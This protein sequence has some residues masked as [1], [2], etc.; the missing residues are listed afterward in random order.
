MHLSTLAHAARRS[1]HAQHVAE[2]LEPEAVKNCLESVETV[3]YDQPITIVGAITVTALSSG[4]AIGASNW[5]LKSASHTVGY[6]G[7]SSSAISR[8]P[9]P[10]ATTA[11]QNCDALIAC[12][13]ARRLGASPDRMVAE[14]CNNIG[15]AIAN[16]GCALVPC[17]PFGVVFDL[18]DAVLAHLAAMQSSTVPIFF[19]SPTAKNSLAYAN[20][21]GHWLCASK[22]ER[23]NSAEWPFNHHNQIAAK[24]LQHFPAIDAAF[25]AAYREPCVVFADHPSLR[26]GDALHFL[27][28]WRANSANALILT[29]PDYGIDEVLAPFLPVAMRASYCPIDPRLGA[30]AFEAVV[31]ETRPRQLLLPSMYAASASYSVKYEDGTILRLETGVPARLAVREPP[32]R[33]ILTDEV[34]RGL[35][36]QSLPSGA[37]IGAFR[38]TINRKDDA[39]IVTRLPA[40]PQ[41]HAALHGTLDSD[42]LV[43]ALQEKGLDAHV[44]DC[45]DGFVVRL[46]ASNASIS[47]LS[48]GTTISTVSNETLRGVL[49]DAVLSQLARF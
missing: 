47:V 29:D 17:A 6:L 5:V 39:N 20:I 13:L 49:R 30:Q 36:L 2:L 35:L 14:L 46:P 37:S 19:V 24:S 1:P 3:S 44:E 43:T 41:T 33:A 21:F 4:Y 27:G 28:L 12:G 22:S 25:L 15:L 8:H 16:G 10:L 40:P 11:M 31:R 48:S 38:A 34:T 9:M 7:P 23:L 32:P 18:F 42:A 45:P 26:M